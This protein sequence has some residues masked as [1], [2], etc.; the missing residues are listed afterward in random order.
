MAEVIQYSHEDSQS[1]TII[2][3]KSDAIIHNVPKEIMQEIFIHCLTNDRSANRRIAPLLL[4]QVCSAWRRLALSSPKLW[5][6]LSLGRSTY[7]EDWE[8]E[9]AM[10]TLANAKTLWFKAS[11][12]RPFSYSLI[13]HPKATAHSP[14]SHILPL[15]SQIRTLD[16][17]LKDDFQLVDYADMQRG[18]M[19][20]LESLR[21]SISMG[22]FVT[23]LALGPVKKYPSFKA[24]AR[25][26]KLALSIPTLR[27]KSAITSFPWSQLTHLAIGKTLTLNCWHTIV[28]ECLQLREF[29]GE[30]SLLPDNFIFPPE[31][32]NRP[33]ILT[34]LRNLTLLFSHYGPLQPILEGLEFPALTA[35]H[36][37]CGDPSPHSSIILGVAEPLENIRTLSQ[38]SE[39]TLRLVD[40]TTDQ[41]IDILLITTN[42]ISLEIDC[43]I[44]LDILLQA[45]YV[46]EGTDTQ[47]AFLPLLQRFSLTIHDRSVA[48]FTS[49]QLFKTVQSRCK[50]QSTTSGIG[51]RPVYPISCLRHI[52]VSV[53]DLHD[54]VL[55]EVQAVL[56]PL[57]AQGLNVHVSNTSSMEWAVLNSFQLFSRWVMWEHE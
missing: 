15:H 54:D 52:S 21:I 8:V 41:L 5:D 56:E 12:E 36:I 10:R 1:T 16:L 3:S 50:P 20:L 22:L 29:I 39:L 28:R 57:K 51:S 31:Y 9:A 48:S 55:T 27:F 18:N 38:L 42:L 45:L 14:G 46:S 44:E 4:C 40:L 49:T 11:R 47:S 53:F 2:I 35:L 34:H 19:P 7:L 37:G 30:F 43:L 6:T 25:L 13:L 17:E 32:N 23:P 24:A 33:M 26:R